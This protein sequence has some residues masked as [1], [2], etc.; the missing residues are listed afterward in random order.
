[1]KSSFFSLKEDFWIKNEYGEDT[2]FVDKKFLSLGLQFDMIKNNEILYSVKE[3]LLTFLSNYEIYNSMEVVAKVNQ[4]LTFMRD[5]IKVDSKY[6]EFTIQGNLF[7]YS[8]RIYKDNMVV[9]KIE[10][11][12]FAFT[13]NYQVDIDFEDE[14]F[15]L[16]L[17]VIIDNIIDKQKD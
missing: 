15:I 7:D 6:G 16:T 2:F 14:A 17:V 9:A 8:Y 11:E 3:K 13:D 4:K 12:L 10:K 5:K 1:M